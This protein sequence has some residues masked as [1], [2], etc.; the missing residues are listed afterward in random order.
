MT[1]LHVII[2]VCATLVSVTLVWP[3]L[4]VIAE[5][6]REHFRGKRERRD[7]DREKVKGIKLQ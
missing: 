1:T 3:T 6:L 7:R 5:A 4:A 2:I